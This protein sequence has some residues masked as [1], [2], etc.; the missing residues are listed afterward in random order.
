M[1]TNIDQVSTQLAQ[2]DYIA[3]NQIA[4]GI[5]LALKLEKPLLVEGPAGV[6]KTELG[7]ALACATKTKLI[8]LQCY[9]GLDE[10]KAL[11]EWNYQKQLLYVQHNDNCTWQDI[12]KDIYSEEF[13][14]PRPILKAFL[15]PVRTTLLIDEVDKSDEEFESFLLE[16]L[17]DFQ[18]SIPELGTITARNKP[19]ILITSNNSRQL[20][21]ALR[22]RCLHLYL[23]YPDLETELQIIS[24]KLPQL[25]HGLAEK[26]V[27]VVQYLRKQDL[28]KPPSVSETLDWAR[29]LETLNVKTLDEKTFSN[30]MMVLLKHHKDMEKA[31][32]KLSGVLKI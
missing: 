11:Y 6:G 10:A 29:S 24:L 3:D 21:D 27:R 7:K 1:F 23:D 8:R 22:R 9:E 25:Q 26:L 18:V 28:Q 2:C 32:E 16:A 12:S 20:S 4:T 15:S 5:Y 30:T 17:S 31:K 13:L 19:Y 14:L